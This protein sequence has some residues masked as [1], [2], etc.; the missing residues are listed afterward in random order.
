MKKSNPRVFF[1]DNSISEHLSI[2]IRIKNSKQRNTTMTFLRTHVEF[3]YFLFL[4]GLVGLVDRNRP[5]RKAK[6]RKVLLYGC[7]RKYF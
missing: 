2:S 5:G 4:S 1:R 7:E 6:V 3:D